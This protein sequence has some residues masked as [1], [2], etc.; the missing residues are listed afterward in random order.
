MSIHWEIKSHYLCQGI[1]AD[2]Q[3]VANR[4]CLIHVG[5]DTEKNGKGMTLMS[6]G[7][8]FSRE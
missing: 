5:R 1:M 3:G 6:I 2:L 7:K 4:G 8:T